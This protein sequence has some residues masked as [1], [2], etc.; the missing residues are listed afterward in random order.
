MKTRLRTYAAY[1]IGCAIV[2]AIILSIDESVGT[3]DHRRAV[4][5]VF[6]GWVIGWF[7]VTLA[8]VIYPPPK[9]RHPVDS[10]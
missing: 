7:S 6:L 9:R 4:L 5:F 8:R 2:W 10:R 1:G 3:H